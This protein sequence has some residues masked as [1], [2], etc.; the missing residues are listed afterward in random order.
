[1]NKSLILQILINIFFICGCYAISSDKKSIKDHPDLGLN[2][3]ITW[4]DSVNIRV[5]YDWS[6]DS[7]LL[8]WVMTNGSTLIRENGGVTINGGD[9]AVRA[10]IWKQGIKCSKILVENAAPL[11]TA[12][13]LNFYCNL[14]SFTGEHYRPNP[15][16][17]AVLAT[18]KNFWTQDGIKEGDIGAPFLVV[19]VVRD[20]E[21]NVSASG[22]TIKS[23]IDDIAY[24]SNNPC[25]PESGRKIA[26]GGWGGNTRWGKLTIEGDISIPWHDEPVPYNYMNIQSNG[27][28]FEPVIEVV[29]DP[30]IEWIFHDST[31]NTSVSPKKYYGSEGSRHNYLKVTPWSALTGINIGYDA[32]DGGYGNFDMVANQNVL[33]FQNLELAK[34]SLKYI[35]ANYNPIAELD[36]TGFT[37]LEFIELYKCKKLI[38]LILKSHP[39]LERLCVEDCSLDSLDI[40]GCN[41]LKDLRAALNNCISIKWGSTGEK[42]WHIC[43]R[44]NPQ[45]KENIPDLT[46]FP[47]LRE[48]LTWN[49]NQTGTFVCHSP[50]IQ[51]IESYRNHYTSADISGC[52]SLTRFSLSGNKLASI[53]LDAAGKLINVRLKDC[54]LIES[55]TDYVLSTLDNAGQS[56]GYLDLEEN[57][58][59]SEEGLEH[60]NN[61]KSKAW[62][63]F[64]TIVPV[65]GI[66][67]L[68]EGGK[69]SI[70]ANNGTL[71]LNADVIPANAT[72]KTVTWSVENITG[73]AEI[74]TTGLVTAITNG[75]VK[76]RA[77]ANDGTGVYATLIINITNQTVSV[78]HSPFGSEKNES[79]KITVTRYEIKTHLNDYYFSW[80]AV[81]YNLK[82]EAVLSKY[83]ESNTL[84]FDISSLSPGIYFQVLSKGENFIHAKVI[85][86]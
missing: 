77:T 42:V 58:A 15:G 26:L 82:G 41:G 24:S 64:V 21:F 86:P 81:L 70:A 55:Q 56:D 37:A 7:Q 66:H 29:G 59:P 8:D 35:C 1:M 52:T 2:G 44:D 84:V 6:D 3:K 73:Q 23:S 25:N 76:A 45:L 63:I 49:N 75:T 11:S 27:P 57:E 60:L 83:V 48:L 40:S 4:I 19:D 39:V 78:D 50:I 16:L 62:T 46:Q 51:I 53:N 31:T 9:V 12:G 30:V 79:L 33:G 10:M 65:N 13:H 80:K 17:G 34:S 18:Y 68:G 69:N 71:Q 36:L 22:M 38:N 32:S 5:E 61:L 85:K 43:I 67:V 54:G 20:Y 28:V 47:V 72:D 14:S 74:S